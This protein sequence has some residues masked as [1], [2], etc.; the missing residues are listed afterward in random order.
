MVLYADDKIK[1]TVEF[2]KV[3]KRA[4]R[5]MEKDK[6]VNIGNKFLKIAQHKKEF[7]W[8]EVD[9]L[10]N[11]YQKNLRPLFVQLRFKSEKD[12]NKWVASV[13]WLKEKLAIRAINSE[14]KPIVLPKHLQKYFLNEDESF[15]INRYEYWL[16]NKIEEN[17]KLWEY[18]ILKIAY[19]IIALI[20][21]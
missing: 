14:D 4:F 10:K 19:Y 9:K 2:Q 5:I 7:Y 20:R 3:R 11:T 12:D 1:D 6:I 15:N 8:K 18:Y 13:N 17:G 16:Y 21:S